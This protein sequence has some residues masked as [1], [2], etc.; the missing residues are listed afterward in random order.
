MSRRTRFPLRVE[1]HL[2]EA[3]ASAYAWYEEELEHRLDPEGKARKASDAIEIAAF[4]V[5]IAVATLSL[6]LTSDQ[7]V[8]VAVMAAIYLLVNWAFGRGMFPAPYRQ[9]LCLTTLSLAPATMPGDAAHLVP[10]WSITL[11]MGF[12]LSRLVMT[13]YRDP[14]LVAFHLGTALAAAATTSFASFSGWTALLV[15]LGGGALAGW[16]AAYFLQGRRS[17]SLLPMRLRREQFHWTL[18]DPPSRLP[19]LLRRRARK[20]EEDSAVERKLGARSEEDAAIDI[21]KIGGAGERRT[22]LL[23]LGLKRGR[24][25]RVAHDV[26]IPGATRGGNADH[27]VLARSGGWVLDS[28]QFGSVKD[29]GVVRRTNT[30]EVV[31]VSGRGSRDLGQTLRTAAWAVRGIRAEMQ[32]PFRGL[33]V[34]HNAEVEDGLSVVVP[35]AL[36]TD[37]DVTVD[38][39]SAKYLVGYLDASVSVMSAW[40]VSAAQWGFQAKLVSATTGDSPQLVAPVGGAPVVVPSARPAVQE[41]EERGSGPGVVSALRRRRSASAGASGEVDGAGGAEDS[42][43]SADSAAVEVGS[44]GQVFPADPVYPGEGPSD[45]VERRIRE[46][47]EQVDVSEPAALDDVPEELRGVGRGVPLSYLSFTED[48]SDVYSVDLVALSG[49]CEG[50]E[51]PF[52]WACDPQ[53]WEIHRRTGRPVMASTVSLDGVAVRPQEGSE[54][55]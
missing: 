16:I 40:E 20:F 51:G 52:V 3:G 47:W 12:L 2:A 44:E 53:Q 19:F 55:S 43:G 15:S 14:A 38:V 34:V 49:P 25:T 36:P 8:L 23:L 17:I 31:H 10:A 45:M 7:P 32:F 18:P 39:I 27:V 37:G 48:F 6:A 21:K 22:G 5:S 29:P 33:L 4:L 11:L 46:R 24:W 41:R 9:T 54:A 28:K 35:G 42:G 30:G 26:Q 1:N 50:L 13:L